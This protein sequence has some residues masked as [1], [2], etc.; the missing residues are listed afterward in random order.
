M[1]SIILSI[2]FVIYIILNKIELNRQLIMLGGVSNI[3]SYLLN[4]KHRVY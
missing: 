1:L 4:F 2:I 3:F